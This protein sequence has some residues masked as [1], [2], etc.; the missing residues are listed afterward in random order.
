VPNLIDF[1]SGT[2]MVK[3][4]VPVCHLPE[5]VTVVAGAGNRLPAANWALDT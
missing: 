3:V 1:P 5:P 2:E 4:Q